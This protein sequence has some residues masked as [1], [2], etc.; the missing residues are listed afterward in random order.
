MSRSTPVGPLV[1][2]GKLLQRE[3]IMRKRG[4]WLLEIALLGL[5]L[6]ANLPVSSRAETGAV[7]V[8]FTKGGFII[9]VGGGRGVLTLH[10]RH[11][12]FRVSGMSVGATIGGSTSQFVGKAL[13]LRGPSD[14]AGNYSAIGASGAMVGGAGGV[15]LQNNANS[16]VLQLS[17]G[18]FGVEL[19]A[20]VSGIQIVM[21]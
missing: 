20:A 21:E 4:I 10:D 8:E 6:A 2:P 11:Y 1:R 7:R 15:L 12:R 16:V 14:L 3:G 9:G 13:H 17:G 19:S 5:L 18:R